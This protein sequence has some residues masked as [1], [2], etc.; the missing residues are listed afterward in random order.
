MD[1]PQAGTAKCGSMHPL[2]PLP[3]QLITVLLAEYQAPVRQALRDLL[4]LEGDLRVVGQAANGRQAVALAGKLSPDVVVMDICMPL[5]TGLEAMQQILQALP[6]TQ[7]IM[8]SSHREDCY[9][10]HARALC[11]AGYVIK[12]T[13]AHLLARA[14]REVHRQKAFFPPKRAASKT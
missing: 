5:I 10:E 1:R 14:I 12:Q 4:A 7:V 3:E 6:T 13:S 11:A 8:L 9:I 2:P